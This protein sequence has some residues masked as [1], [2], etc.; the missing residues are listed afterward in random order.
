M[1]AVLSEQCTGDGGRTYRKDLSQRLMDENRMDWVKSII[2]SV[3]N[4]RAIGLS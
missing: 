4:D 2:E 1:S 3:E